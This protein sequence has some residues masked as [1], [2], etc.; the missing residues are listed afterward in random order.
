[1]LII[2]LPSFHHSGWGLVKDGVP[3][4]AIQEERL[5]RIKH[6]PYYTDL[7]KHPMSMGVEYLFRGFDFSIEDCGLV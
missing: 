4:R 1:M 6:Y 7:K 5:N 2:G 3:L